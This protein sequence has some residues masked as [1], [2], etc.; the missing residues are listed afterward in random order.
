[1]YLTACNVRAVYIFSYFKRIRKP[2]DPGFSEFH[3]VNV[4]HSNLKS[5][6][7]KKMLL[8]ITFLCVLDKCKDLEMQGTESTEKGM[9]M[10]T[11]GFDYAD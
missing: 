8:S 7:S 1:M 9:V 11:W 3:A 5:S 2:D 10:F 6:P 4:Y